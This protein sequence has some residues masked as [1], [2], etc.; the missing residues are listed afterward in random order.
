MKTMRP[1]TLPYLVFATVL[2]LPVAALPAA[3]QTGVWLPSQPPVNGLG[4]WWELRTDGTA[5]YSWGAFAEARYTFDG[6]I[7]TVIP[8]GD[9]KDHPR[10]H[11]RFDNDRMYS[12]A[13]EAGAPEAE[14]RRTSPATPN[15]S[16]A[17][18]MAWRVVGQWASVSAPKAA[19]KADMPDMADMPGMTGPPHDM[20]SIRTFTA[21]GLYQVR[22]VYNTRQ[23]NWTAS[24]STLK[25]D[26]EAEQR[27]TF[28]D[29]ALI[30]SGETY[31][32]N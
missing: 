28:K 11:L 16:A 7:L 17:A 8:G 24:S 4:G 9:R 31:R 12:R 22:I 15:P 2:L 32:P 26:G 27:F 20:P 29:G 13:D 23:G 3:A 14:Y 30:I 21:D 25:L 5:T 10:F 6:V 19:P 18:T 1:L